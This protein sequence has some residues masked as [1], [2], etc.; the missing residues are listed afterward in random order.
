VIFDTDM[1]NDLDDVFALA[2]L[3]GLADRGECA[4]L[5]VTVSKPHPLAGPFCDALNTACGRPDLPIGVA[6]PADATGDGPYLRELLG[7]DAAE[8]FPHDLKDSGDAPEPAAV[9]RRAL[10]D[11]PDGS[12]VLIGVG[13]ATNLAALLR[14]GPDTASPLDGRD[15]AA[16]KVSRLVLM[17]GDF[18]RARPE[19][20]VEQDV[21]AARA[22]LDGW[23]TP[24]VL[25]PFDVGHRVPY[26]REPRFAA[27]APGERGKLL[28]A[29]D[30][31]TF[32]HPRGFPAW[33][34]SATLHAVR[35]DAGAFALSPPGTVRLDD[36]GATALEPDPGGR[37]RY[38]IV[39]PGR[40][41]AVQDAF[42]ELVERPA[43]RR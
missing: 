9:L 12:V 36:R 19:F 5:A 3:H 37:H 41:G 28:L 2:L 42:V 24:V 17:A 34:L 1:G 32:G 7:P 31:A 40:I 11:A 14:S 16:R 13:P 26:P 15:L 22:V 8:P 39:E 38:L 33:D 29:A 20:N 30:V 35:P 27:D 18:D 43:P 21:P 10:A 25:C 6:R 4:I 23:P